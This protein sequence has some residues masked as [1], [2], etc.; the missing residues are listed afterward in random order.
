VGELQVVLREA[1]HAGYADV[2]LVVLETDGSFSVVPTILDGPAPAP[3]ALRQVPPGRQPEEACA[4]STG[5]S[6]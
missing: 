2:D 6:P 3:D 5:S 1:G 4:T